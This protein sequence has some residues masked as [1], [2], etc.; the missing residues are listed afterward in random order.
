MLSLI[1]YWKQCFGDEIVGKEMSES[2]SATRD[3]TAQARPSQT[4]PE[5]QPV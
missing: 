1:A 4:E 2:V 3:D 5:P